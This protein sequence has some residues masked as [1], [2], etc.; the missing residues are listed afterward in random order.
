MRVHP[1]PPTIESEVFDVAVIGAGINGCGIAR[2]CALRGLRVVLLDQADIGS[3]TTAWSTRLIH[4]GLRYLEH[5]EFGLVRE[6]LREREVLL[7]IAPHLVRPV[8]FLLPIYHEQRLGPLKIRA[9]MIAYDLLSADK[10]LPRHRMLSRDEV[11]ALAPGLRADGLLAGATYYDAQVTWPERLALENALDAVDHGATLLT[12]VMATRIGESIDNGRTLE[13]R[14]HLTG[15]TFTVRASLVLNVT[16]P[17]LDDLVNQHSN[18]R[19]IGGTR[20]S[21]IIVDPF[22]GAPLLPIYVEARDGRPFFIVPWNGRYLIGTTDMRVDHTPH[23]V[24]ATPEEIDYL[25]EQACRVLPDCGLTRDSVLFIWAGVRPL[26]HVPTG[27]TGAITR[28]HILHRH[29]GALVGVISVIGGKL[30]TYRALAEQAT[31]AVIRSLGRSPVACQTASRPLPGAKWDAESVRTIA[32]VSDSAVRN[33]LVAL[34]GSRSNLVLRLMD[35]HPQLVARLGRSTALA[36]EIVHGIRAERAETIGDLLFRR[37]TVALSPGLG[38]DLLD[39]VVQIAA[40]E[41]GWSDQRVRWERDGYVTYCNRFRVTH[42]DRG[43]DGTGFASVVT[44]RGDV[45]NPI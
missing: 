10:S 12:H 7:R 38:I 35:Q 2:D 43:S 29:G 17:W 45:S 20:G 39:E 23:S 11:L 28:R 6:S 5:A 31:T 14:D 34:Y 30:T 9:G 22:P 24:V 8:R 37:M 3:G 19:L 18:D 15:D 25:I 44:P 1:I 26:P 42:I 36:A 32:G 41:L 40:T 33:R 21:H 13:C 4:G 16:G 27:S